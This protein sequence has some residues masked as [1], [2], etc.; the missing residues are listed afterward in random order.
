MVVVNRS[1]VLIT[2]VVML[3]PII[4]TLKC[5]SGLTIKILFPLAVA[6]SSPEVVFV[7][8]NNERC[9]INTLDNHF[10]SSL[11]WAALLGKADTC[12]LLLDHHA[13]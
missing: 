12:R 11:H 2:R 10:R 13:R 4:V 1:L 6:D 3:M 9:S 8:L 7:L 5:V